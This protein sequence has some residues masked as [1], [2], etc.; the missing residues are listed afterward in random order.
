MRWGVQS[1]SRHGLHG[2]ALESC[3][4][5]L[6]LDPADPLGALFLADYLALRAGAHDWLARMD[7]DWEQAAGGAGRRGA[8]GDAG[9]LGMLPNFAFSLA[10]AAFRR[11]QPAS[12]AMPRQRLLHT[13]HRC[14]RPNALS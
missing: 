9:S 6:A 4:L 5:L 12:G 11:E 10:L 7:A 3:K 2:T 14:P 1:L 13:A 8:Q